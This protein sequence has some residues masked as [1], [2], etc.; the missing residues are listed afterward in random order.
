MPAGRCN[1]RS[2]VCLTIWLA[3]SVLTVCTPLIRPRCAGLEASII[4]DI[5]CHHAHERAGLIALTVT[6]VAA[7]CLPMLAVVALAVGSAGL[8][9]HVFRQPATIPAC[10]LRPPG[11]HVRPGATSSKTS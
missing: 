5:G 7:T 8:M 3:T 11:S 9:R 10:P 2:E 6:V 1:G 4:V